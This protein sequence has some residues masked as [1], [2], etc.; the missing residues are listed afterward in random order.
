MKTKL[1]SLCV[2]LC[3][4]TNIT[5][6][7]SL[8]YQQAQQFA[9]KQWAQYKND[10]NYQGYIQKWLTINNEN[11]IDEKNNCYAQGS[12]PTHMVLIQNRDGVIEKVVQ[13]IE[14]EKAKCFTHSYLGLEFPKPP[15]AP[16]YH[17]MTMQ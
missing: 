6:N 1:V 10:Q 5:S 14:N 13:K 3:S 12:G 2:F 11:K 8:T 17:I 16:F 7:N 9:D 15:V 4:C